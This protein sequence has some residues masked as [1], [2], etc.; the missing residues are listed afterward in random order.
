LGVCAFTVFTFITHPIGDESS[1]PYDPFR[2]YSYPELSADTHSTLPIEAV[3]AASAGAQRDFH[4]VNGQYQPSIT[5]R[6]GEPFVVRVLH[7]SGGKPLPVTLSDSAACNLSV[8]AWDGVYLDANLYE[9]EEVRLVAAS[10]VEL[11]LLCGA[12]GQY[13]LDTEGEV[14]LHIVV[15]ASE[16]GAPSR[17]AYISDADLASI[18]RPYYLQDLTGDSGPVSVDSAYSV[19]ISQDHTDASVCGF[20]IGAGTD[21]SSVNASASALCPY[22]QFTG[23]KGSSVQPYLADHKLVTFPGAV[24]EWKFYGMGSAFHPLHVHVNHFQIIDYYSQ[25]DAGADKYY[26]R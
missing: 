2:V 22:H 9:E 12:P 4:F 14:L 20:W 23:Q 13:S 1:S 17:Y 16:A 26:R 18:N 25:L 15:S 8:I 6:A 5:V 19:T 10:R 11:Q 24:N 7:A 21:C 3:F